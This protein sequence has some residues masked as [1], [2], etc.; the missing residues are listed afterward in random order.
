MNSFLVSTLR[1]RSF[2]QLLSLQN[3]GL[4]FP[5]IRT[6]SSVGN[7]FFDITNS[8]EFVESIFNGTKPHELG[9]EYV[10][11]RL[12]SLL[13]KPVETGD[14]PEELS[15]SERQVCIHILE[16]KQLDWTNYQ[17]LVE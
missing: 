11:K 13:D 5:L 10:K 8:K 6:S 17:K 7:A 16:T 3:G 2:A 4:A 15:P 9:T 14:S 1:R 12:T